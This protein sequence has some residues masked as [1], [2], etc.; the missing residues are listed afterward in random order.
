MFTITACFIYVSL[1]EAQG[2]CQQ[3][4]HVA[5]FYVSQF[6]TFNEEVMER[7]LEEVMMPFVGEDYPK[8]K[9]AECLLILEE[10]DEMADVIF[11]YFI[12]ENALLEKKITSSPHVCE[13]I[14]VD[15]KVEVVGF[16]DKEIREYVE[17][18]CADD[19]ESME[20]FM[21]EQL[22]NLCYVP[23]NLAMII[24]IFCFS[25]KKLS[26]TLTELYRLF[27]IMILQREVVK[28]CNVKK[29]IVGDNVE[30]TLCKM[31]AGISKEPV[32]IVNLLYKLAYCAVFKSYSDRDEYGNVKNWKNPKIVFPES[33]FTEHDIEVINKFDGYISTLSQQE[34]LNSLSDNFSYFPNV[35]IY[36]CILTKL[37]SNKFV[38][39]KLSS[40]KA[41]VYEDDPYIVTTVRCVYK[42]NHSDPSQ[43]SSPFT[44][45]MSHNT[46]SPCD[47]LHLSWLSCFSLKIEACHIEDTWAKLLV[48]YYPNKN[49][50]S[51]LLEKLNLSFNY[52]TI[53]RLDMMK[54]VRTSKLHYSLLIY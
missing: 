28:G 24:D 45:E 10:L 9:T 40:S 37:A 47:C 18:L 38:C 26:S 22:H 21:R 50:T 27:I 53:A 8:L 13:N 25:Q 51:Q 34:Q 42:S 52:L 33:D 17:N 3:Q 30:V 48:R 2:V 1:S 41:R 16:R 44:L 15:R 23:L 49:T 4:E 7:S 43:S 20:E 39:S 5:N 12:E 32:G 54:I 14:V 29:L 31:L 46:L 35:M 11:K 36:L 6:E 19:V